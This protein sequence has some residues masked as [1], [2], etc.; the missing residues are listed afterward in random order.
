MMYLSFG[1][2]IA[3]TLLV[4]ITVN[5]QSTTCFVRVQIVYQTVKSIMLYLGVVN[6]HFIRRFSRE[7]I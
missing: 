1:N 4:K 3:Y 7:I 6:E 5:V 2:S